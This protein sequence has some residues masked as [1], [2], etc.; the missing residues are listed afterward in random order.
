MKKLL[1]RLYYWKENLQVVYTNLTALL[2]LYATIFTIELHYCICYLF[3]AMDRRKK[4]LA[5]YPFTRL[6]YLWR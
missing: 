5:N 4:S 6:F 3:H 1:C 2:F